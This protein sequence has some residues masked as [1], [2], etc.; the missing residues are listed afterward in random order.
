MIHTYRRQNAVRG[1]D[2]D[3]NL[4][5]YL[6]VDSLPHK[7][8]FLVVDNIQL[9]IRYLVLWTPLKILKEK[10]KGSDH[11]ISTTFIACILVPNISL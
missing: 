11:D 5:S 3:N 6:V 10:V 2:V 7:R 1:D 8:C 9:S 4:L